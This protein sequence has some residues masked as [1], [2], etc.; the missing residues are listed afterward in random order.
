MSTRAHKFFPGWKMTHDQHRAYWSL[1][2][3]VAKAMGVKSDVARAAIHERAFGGRIT[4]AKLINHLRDFD[5]F[6]AA[7]LAALQPTNLEA[8]LRQA[9]MPH[10]RLIYA[11]RQ[12]APE[13]Y[14]IAEARRKFGVADWEGLNESDLTMLRNHLAARAADIRWPEQHDDR[15]HA[16]RAAAVEREAEC[17]F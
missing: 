4:S 5:D 2:N 12:L 14:I 1:V 17:P 7:C 16:A 8:Q 9:E 13:A 10:M 3:R 11:V 6:K 15:D